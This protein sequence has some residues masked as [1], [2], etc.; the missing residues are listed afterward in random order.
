MPNKDATIYEL[1]VTLEDTDPPIWRRIAVPSTI[2]LRR[3]HDAIQLAF[4][5]ADSH[6]HLW[7]I[8]RS[9]YGIEDPDGFTKEL[10]DRRVRLGKVA[11]AVGKSFLYVYDFGD[12]WRHQCTVDAVRI[13][14]AGEAYPCLLDGARACPPEDVGGVYTYQTRFL[15]AIADPA[16]EEHDE[17]LVW[18]G[19]RFDPAQFNPAAANRRLAR[20]R[21]KK[22]STRKKNARVQRTELEA[23]TV[24]QAFEMASNLCAV[25]NEHFELKRRRAE[26]TLRGSV[27]TV[28]EWIA[29]LPWETDWTRHPTA[30]LRYDAEQDAWTLFQK[31]QGRWFPY[32]D[33]PEA[34]DV[35]VLL[36]EIKQDE[37]CVFWG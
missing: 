10:D 32:V 35:R 34:N 12:D 8:G 16:N 14:I 19:R 33:S 15:P 30:Q 36:D 7:L 28:S 24:R 25:L 13:A 18:A 23:D 3:L 1:T 9:R 17:L 11:P 6:L 26:A 2:T 29:P 21:P 31:F 4:G 27:I 5:W 22:T 37:T 20:L